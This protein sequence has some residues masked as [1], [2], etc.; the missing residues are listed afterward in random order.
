M[1][2]EQILNLSRLIYVSCEASRSGVGRFS[3][4]E[5]AS[6][7]V[8]SLYIAKVRLLSRNPGWSEATYIF[9]VSRHNAVSFGNSVESNIYKI[10]KKNESNTSP[11]GT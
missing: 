4:W 6:Q 7:I 5:H 9:H 2:K 3:A 10:Y 11:A 1:T 8:R